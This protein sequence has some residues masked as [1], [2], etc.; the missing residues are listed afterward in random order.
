MLGLLIMEDLDKKL[1]EKSST[2]QQSKKLKLI[3]Y[4]EILILVK[5]FFRSLTS[6]IKSNLK[7]SSR[8]K[9]AGSSA[10]SKV[11]KI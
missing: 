3:L 1:T 4:D 9:D 2:M 10:K 7:N 5:F 11:S 6:F 8:S